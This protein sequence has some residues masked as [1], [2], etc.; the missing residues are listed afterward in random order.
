EWLASQTGGASVALRKLVEEAMRSP[1]AER[2]LA[3]EVTYRFMSSIAGDLPGFEEAARALFAS[4]R[5]KFM[6]QTQDW[7]LDVR[8]YALRQAASAF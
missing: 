3:Q 4:D 6:R 7:P 2:R 5:G 8:D 1:A